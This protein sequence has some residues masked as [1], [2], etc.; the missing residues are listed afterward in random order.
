MAKQSNQKLKLLYLL[1]ILVE[2]TDAERGM[3]LSEI[4]AELAKYNIGAARKSLYDD[5]ESLRVQRMC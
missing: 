1:K 3:T 5:I 2:R 4:S